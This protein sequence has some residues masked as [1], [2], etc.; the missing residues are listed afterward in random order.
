MERS[1]GSFRGLRKAFQIMD[2]G[3]DLKLDREDLK[4]GLY[5]IGVSL[6]DDQFD[7]LMNIFDKNRDGLVSLTE[8]L[9]TI[10]GEM[11]DGRLRLVRMA[12]DLLDKDGSGKITKED[13]VDAYDFSKNPEVAS[14]EMS[15]DD[16]AM[17]FLSNFERGSV[18]G[19]V[20]YEEFVEYYRDIS[21][22]I[23]DDEYWELMIRNAWHISGGEGAAANSSCLRVLVI[24]HDDSM[25]VRHRD[26]IV[27]KSWHARAHAHAMISSWNSSCLSVRVLPFSSGVARVRRA[28]RHGTSCVMERAAAACAVLCVPPLH[29]RVARGR[30]TW[31]S[32]LSTTDPVDWLSHRCCLVVVSS[33]RRGEERPRARHVRRRRHHRQAR[34]AGRHRHQGRRHGGGL[35]ACGVFGDIIPVTDIQGRRRHGGGLLAASERY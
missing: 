22:E 7:S 6:D 24:H 34:V 26:A 16:A 8:F 10:R 28:V 5:D 30:I 25:E 13:L 32:R 3:R 17:G 15:Y 18:D 11:N 14:G 23:D 12:F 9:T 35:L 19:V 1:K 20:T 29:R 33:G 21:A 4:W 27:M 31:R 2:D